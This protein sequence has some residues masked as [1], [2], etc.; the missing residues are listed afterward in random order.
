MEPKPAK[1]PKEAGKRV[2]LT[3]APAATTETPTP[4]ATPEV[5]E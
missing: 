3:A 1:P 5:K 4:T 2:D